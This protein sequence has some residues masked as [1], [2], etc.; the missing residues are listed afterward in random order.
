[1]SATDRSTVATSAG[2]ISQNNSLTSRERLRP[3]RQQL[4]PGGDPAEAA[5]SGR[6]LE[7]ELQTPCTAS[8][9][10]CQPAPQD[11]F[12]ALDFLRLSATVGWPRIAEEA[13]RQ[14]RQPTTNTTATCSGSVTRVVELLAGLLAEEPRDCIASQLFEAGER[15]IARS[16]S[17]TLRGEHLVLDNGRKR[18]PTG[19]RCPRQR[20]SGSSSAHPWQIAPLK[21]EFH[22]ADDTGHFHRGPRGTS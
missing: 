9:C 14:A 6:R 10:R 18:A 19:E 3:T 15:K 8:S 11:P 13:A 5:P 22:I 20:V 1:M 7:G 12:T 21:D 2:P 16:G 17:S 4:E